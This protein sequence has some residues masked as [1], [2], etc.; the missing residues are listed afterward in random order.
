MMRPLAIDLML[1]RID[2]PAEGSTID[3]DG[4]DALWR[5][6]PAFVG[7]CEP[8]MVRHLRMGSPASPWEV[9]ARARR[10]G[11]PGEQFAFDFGRAA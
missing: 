6:F 4:L 5:P 11:P 3:C 8:P 2:R 10:A 9:A 7:P 1:G